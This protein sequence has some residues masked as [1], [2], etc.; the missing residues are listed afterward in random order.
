MSNPLSAAKNPLSV[1][2]SNPGFCGVDRHLALAGGGV[3]TQVD[4]VVAAVRPVLAVDGVLAAR[5]DADL[6][7]PARCT[8]GH[9]GALPVQ[10][11]RPPPG[12]GP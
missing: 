10:M 7:D 2:N 6:R 3:D 5:V 11:T 8:N 9:L 12:I 1:A 4:V